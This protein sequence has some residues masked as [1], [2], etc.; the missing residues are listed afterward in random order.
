VG[1]AAD[2]FSVFRAFRE[3]F[4]H[5]GTGYSMSMSMGFQPSSDDGTSAPSTPA[6]SP[7]TESN[8]VTPTAATTPGVDTPAPSASTEPPT[9]SPTEDSTSVEG[10]QEDTEATAS[11]GTVESAEVGAPTQTAL[12]AIVVL[13]VAAVVGA[14][15]ARKVYVNTRKKTPSSSIVSDPSLDQLATGDA[16]N[17]G[18]HM[19][20]VEI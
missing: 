14:L 13:A 2:F 5:R 7:G 18:N 15:V 12:I 6:D 17:V 11:E 8:S 3:L 19:S 16:S 10:V 9:V 1:A 20:N 4:Q